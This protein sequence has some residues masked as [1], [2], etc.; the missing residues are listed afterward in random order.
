MKKLNALIVI[1]L[2][3]SCFLNHILT[4][5]NFDWLSILALLTCI[6]LMFILSFSMFFKSIMEAKKVKLKKNWCIERIKELE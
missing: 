5:S 3:A 6:L 2:S 1:A 4:K